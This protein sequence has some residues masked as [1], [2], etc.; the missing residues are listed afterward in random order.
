MNLDLIQRLS[1]IVPRPVT[2]LWPGRLALGKL[3]MFDGDPEMGKS[4]VALDLA[5][6]LTSG[7]PF[8]GCDVAPQPG[9]VIILHG[10]DDAEDTVVPRLQALGADLDRVFIFSKDFMDRTGPFRLPLH[11]EFL[12]RALEQS[13][14]SLVVL[15]PIM[16]FLDPTIQIASD[17]SVRRAL[18]PLAAIAGRHAA[19]VDM[20][21][22]LNKSGRHQSIYRGG[23]SI[24][25]LAACR[26]AFLFARD[27]VDPLRSVMAQIKN[28]LA[29][30]QP[31]FAYRLRVQD[32]GLPVVEWLGESSL[33]ADQLLAAAGRKPYLA[34]PRDHA[35]DFLFAFLDE[36]PRSTLDIW[37]AAEQQGLSQ[38]TLRRVRKKAGL[39]CKSVWTDNRLLTY[40]MLPGQ[41]LPPE[42]DPP[43]P[44]RPSLEPYLAPLREQYPT[45]PLDDDS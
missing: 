5:A 8:P 17:M 18:T 20:V 28:N 10:E 4:L 2:W 3:T 34:C 26:S 13:R 19:H 36:G 25:L 21:R 6:R 31:S 22:H 40:W 1:G 42:I 41:Q 14:A 38:R 23:G 11:T 30:P 15:D 45:T 29:A 16:A 32:G 12:D 44:D 43:N 35:H 37:P 9:N 39:T 7:R 27:P 33:G 24:G